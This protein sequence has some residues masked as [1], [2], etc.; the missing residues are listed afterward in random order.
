[1]PRSTRASSRITKTQ[2]DSINEQVKQKVMDAAGPMP[3]FHD[4]L[5]LNRSIYG[6]YTRQPG[7]GR[8]SWDYIAPTGGKVIRI[9]VQYRF[10]E[11][12][13][14]SMVGR[15]YAMVRGHAS[16]V[17]PIFGSTDL[18]LLPMS[19]FSWT[20]ERRLSF[21]TSLLHSSRSKFC[22][23]IPSSLA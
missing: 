2:R 5:S 18:R 3:K 14:Q 9:G 1:M 16:N 17:I 20:I 21:I 13:D 7:I 23:S 12:E 6:S 15:Y 19:R 22:R 10:D 4:L 11:V 8:Y